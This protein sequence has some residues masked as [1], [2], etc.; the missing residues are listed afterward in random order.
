MDKRIEALDNL[1][2]NGTVRLRAGTSLRC[3]NGPQSCMFFKGSVTFCF[4][5]V[6]VDP[7]IPTSLV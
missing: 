2:E 7:L 5:I 4:V 3:G 1:A 6:A